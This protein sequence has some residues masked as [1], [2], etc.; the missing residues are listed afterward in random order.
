MTAT[1]SNRFR[2]AREQAGLTLGQASRLLGIPITDLSGMELDKMIATEA[3]LTAMQDRYGVSR[4]WLVGEGPDRDYAT[5]DAMRGAENLS[6]HDRVVLA[7]F[8]AS[9]PRRAANECTNYAPRDY[10][11]HW[12]EW[13]RGHGCGLDAKKEKP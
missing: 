9:L 4:A 6:T 12:R 8:A 10:V 7:E 1:A 5:I 13:H 3:A 11:G 2:K